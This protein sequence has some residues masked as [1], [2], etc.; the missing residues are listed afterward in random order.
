MM[1]LVAHR[2]KSEGLTLLHIKY[3][4]DSF[5]AIAIVTKS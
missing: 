5:K 2:I 4:V 1:L 3:Q